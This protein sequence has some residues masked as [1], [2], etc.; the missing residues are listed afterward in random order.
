MWPYST[1][2][3]TGGGTKSD[4]P[5]REVDLK[6][7]SFNRSLGQHSFASFIYLFHHFLPS[8]SS[9]VTRC[10]LPLPSISLTPPTVSSGVISFLLCRMSPS[11]IL[12]SS[13]T[14]PALC[15][16]TM[17][18][19]WS[20]SSCQRFSIH[21][22]SVCCVSAMLLFSLTQNEQEHIHGNG[23]L[24]PPPPALFTI[25]HSSIHPSLR[26]LRAPEPPSLTASICIYGCT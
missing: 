4:M 18:A 15:R 2:V 10:I 12:P 1:V 21:Q 16:V 5:R 13:V 8:S 11:V 6:P 20:L 26:A 23:S 24:H 14:F 3:R 22:L 17:V 19:V 7:S 9:C 25:T